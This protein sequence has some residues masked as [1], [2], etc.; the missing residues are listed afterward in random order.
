LY[1]DIQC[2]SVEI[3]GSST[4][5]T[6]ALLVNKRDIFVVL[7]ELGNQSSTAIRLGLRF[8]LYDE[9]CVCSISSVVCEGSWLFMLTKD[10]GKIR[11]LLCHP[12]MFSNAFC[13]FILLHQTSGIMY[14]AR[15]MLLLMH[16]YFVI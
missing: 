6:L 1:T 16:R 2:N 11:I 8:P 3:V 4:P 14:R 13:E 12:F 9:D 7:M 5:G 10:T 15:N